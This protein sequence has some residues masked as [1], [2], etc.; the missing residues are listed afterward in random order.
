MSSLLIVPMVRFSIKYHQDLSD[1]L[2]LPLIKDGENL[3]HGRESKRNN[4][5]FQCFHSQASWVVGLQ[6][7]YLS[8]LKM[9]DVHFGSFSLN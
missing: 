8:R 2:T 1:I 6:A 9:M 3:C 4:F 7:A 5:L